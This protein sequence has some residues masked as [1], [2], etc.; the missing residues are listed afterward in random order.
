MLQTLTR[1]NNMLN[2]PRIGNTI[3]L[4]NKPN[5]CAKDGSGGD[6]VGPVIVPMFKEW[7]WAKDHDLQQIVG[8]GCF[9]CDGA[10]PHNG[11]CWTFFMNGT[12]YPVT[13]FDYAKACL[14]ESLDKTHQLK[15]KAMNITDEFPEELIQYGVTL[16]NRDGSES[17]HSIRW[18]EWLDAA[19]FGETEVREKRASGFRIFDEVS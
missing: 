5:V 11:E 10:D 13:M 9:A 19:N 18:R 2:K 1:P 3:C 16:I 7:F 15:S 4:A 6:K 8:S 17:N 14:P 12:G